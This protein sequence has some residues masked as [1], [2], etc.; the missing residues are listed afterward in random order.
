MCCKIVDR[1]QEKAFG[2][3]YPL[4]VLV[5]DGGGGCQQKSRIRHRLHDKSRNQETVRRNSL[6]SYAIKGCGIICFLDL[7]E[8]VEPKHLAGGDRKQ[9]T[10]YM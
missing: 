8:E 2:I 1:G 4:L 3:V 5:V 9:R 7:F 6:N 10:L